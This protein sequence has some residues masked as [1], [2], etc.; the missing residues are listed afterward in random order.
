M[1]LNC[2][3]CHMKSPL[4][5]HLTKE[6][7]ESISNSKMQ[8]RFKAGELI[9]KQGTPLT[10][11]ISFTSGIAKVYIE[12]PNNKDLILQFLKPTQF[13]GGP[14][15]FIDNKHQYSIAAI[16]DSSVCFIEIKAFKKVIRE[17]QNFAEGFIK[18]IS[19]N[20]AFN[21]ERFISLTQKNM[22]GRIAD[23]ILYLYNN[24][25]DQKVINIQRND[26]ADF[27]G[28]SNDSVIRVLKD[29][30]TD[31]IIDYS[32]KSITVRNL[33]KLTHISQTG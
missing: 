8:V 27:T 11:V 24:V 5:Q 20:G 17:N 30:S 14:G 6:E 13:L 10:S 29:F 33:D 23:G 1:E 12:G 26:I 21:Y 32:D 18:E 2:C 16:E 22:S 4:F 9:V 31:G 25:F 15:I 7:L 28:M 19:A 3:N